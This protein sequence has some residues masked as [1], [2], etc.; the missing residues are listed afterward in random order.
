M[1]EWKIY[2]LGDIA[3]FQTGKLNSNAAVS[4]GQ[5]PF[6]TCSPITLSIDTWAF[7][8][9]AIILA[10]NN[11]EGNFSIKYYKGKFNAY[12]RT[13]IIEAMQGVCDTK[14][15]YYSLKIFLKHFKRLSQGTSTKFLTAVILRSIEISLP[16]LAEQKRIA[17]ILSAIDDK[18][19]L[20]RR[21]NANLEQQ[22]QALYKSWFVD[23]EF[24]NEEGKPY[25]S[26]GGK[27]QESELGLIPN[28]WHV[29]K[30]SDIADITMGQSPVGTS[31]NDCGNGVVFY[32]GRTEFGFRFPSIKLFTTAPTRY[33]E[34]M[35]VL[36]SVRA[37]VGDI[38]IAAQKCC[39]GR[40]LASIKSKNN[41]NSFM[42]YCLNALK[43][44]LE[45]YNGEG[46]VFGSINKKELESLKISI[47]NN[48]IIANFNSIINRI[49][50]QILNLSNEINNLSTLR[51]TLLPK[52]MS[53]EITV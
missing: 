26:S 33:A 44:Q 14:F 37:P 29:G 41:H 8:K 45:Q 30:L 42:Y 39:I 23:F 40:G 12:Q 32:Q 48:L 35:S 18:I 13:Y 51:D 34:P 52:L 47:P 2:K 15:L 31:Y 19:E 27:M 5:Y 4:N 22:A 50:T 20:N 10:G 3:T 46:T 28:Y 16:P 11:A 6:F 49:D 21:I 1:S 17:D 36:L 25:K 53:G 43:I 9:E 24:P 7:D 38:N